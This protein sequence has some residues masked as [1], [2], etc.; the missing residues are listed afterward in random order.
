MEYKEGFK[1]D[2]NNYTTDTEI[3]SKN[4]VVKEAPEFSDEEGEPAYGV[5]TGNTLL[6]IFW[7]KEF[8][9]I[10][11]ESIKNVSIKVSE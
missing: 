6:G 4:Y 7:N 5:Y 9:D 1:K 10:F 3:L 11:R 2:V 8:A